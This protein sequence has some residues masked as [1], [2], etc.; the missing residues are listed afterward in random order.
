[1][2]LYQT[3]ITK[4]NSIF[5][6][7]P[8][9]VFLSLVGLFLAFRVHFLPFRHLGMVFRKT[10]GSLGKSSGGTGTVSQFGAMCSSL[11]ATV[12]MGNIVGVASAVCLGGP[13][14]VFWMIIAAF[15]GAIMKYFGVALTI[16][17]REKNDAGEYYGGPSLYIAK[18]LKLPWL[19]TIMT[20]LLAI[21]CLCGNMIQSNTFLTNFNSFI[22][23]QDTNSVLQAVI[24]ALIIAV[25]IMGGIK[26]LSKV[27]EVLVPVMSITYLVGGLVVLVLNAQQIPHAIV[28]IFQGAFTPVA[29]SGGAV[30]YGFS[31]AARYGLA[32]GFFS[33]GGGS[34]M[35]VVTHAAAKVDNPIDQAVWAIVEIF[36]DCSIC[37]ISALTV[38]SSGVAL[39]NNS[40]ATLV[41][42]AFGMSYAPLEYVVSFSI[43]LFTFTTVAGFCYMG[44]AQLGSLIKSRYVKLYRVL[45]VI[46]C[47]VGCISDLTSLWDFS[48]AL[49]GV[50][51]F[52]NLPV[53]VLLSS[54]V[55]GMTNEFFC[56]KNDNT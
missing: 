50:I 4:A 25:V 3:I 52:I 34:G 48:D 31:V 53:M 46:L 10:L 45:F 54:K 9:L 49:I 8:A 11:A 55:T 51:M 33:N 18:G 40:A 56:G 29:V 41:S 5:W 15:L 17:Y 7:T 24:F 38:I 13:G 26:S 28:Q 1:M 42:K 37:L 27:S 36:L 6:G 22:P 2:S 32:R 16:L 12:G 39:D 14:A 23:G 20:I 44:E 21:A 30:G 43:L 19:G 35:Y 47:F